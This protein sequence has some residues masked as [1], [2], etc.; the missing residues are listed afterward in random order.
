MHNHSCILPPPSSQL[1]LKADSHLYIPVRHAELTPDY[2]CRCLSVCVVV[3]VAS[4]DKNP[5]LPFCMLEPATHD[6]RLITVITIIDMAR[7]TEHL[8]NIG[9]SVLFAYSVLV[10]E[11]YT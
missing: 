2:V 11:I 4:C 3:F 1:S 10:S 5:G 8:L 6:D 9:F 7:G